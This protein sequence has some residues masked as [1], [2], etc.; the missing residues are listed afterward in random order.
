MA[1]E[2]ADR[3]LELGIG[4]VFSTVGRGREAVPAV[5]TRKPT[6]VVEAGLAG[7][8][9]YLE[10][11]SVDFHGRHAERLPMRGMCRKRLTLV[12][13][14]YRWSC[15]VG[16]GAVVQPCAIAPK[17]CRGLCSFDL[18]TAFP[19][20][21]DGRIVAAEDPG[22]DPS[23]ARPV[24]DWRQ[25][26]YHGGGDAMPPEVRVNRIAKIEVPDVR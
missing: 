9:G 2:V 3:V 14:R 20:H 1:Q 25:P 10:T 26:G 17:D 13:A 8:L 23:M 24:K 11:L 15:P 16:D 7:P 6:N 5:R 18:E 4:L 12:I 19:Q 21:A 22:D